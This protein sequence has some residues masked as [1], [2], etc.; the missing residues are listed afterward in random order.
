MKKITL[1]LIKHKA[2]KQIAFK[3]QYDTQI[4]EYLKKLP[5]INWSQTHRA[6]YILYTKKI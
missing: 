4:K 1:T 5:N 6:F 3:F 2:L